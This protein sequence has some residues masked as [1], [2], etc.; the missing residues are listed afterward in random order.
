MNL[1]VRNRY[2]LSKDYIKITDQLKTPRLHPAFGRF[3]IKS[4]WHPL[5]GIS[6][7]TSAILYHPWLREMHANRANK[8][9]IILCVYHF[10]HRKLL[11]IKHIL[12]PCSVFEVVKRHITLNSYM[13]MTQMSLVQNT[14]SHISIYDTVRI[15]TATFLCHFHVIITTRLRGGN[16][17]QRALRALWCKRFVTV[18]QFS[19]F[20]I[21]LCA[22]YSIIC[23]HE[24][25]SIMIVK[26]IIVIVCIN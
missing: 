20:N 12:H 10:L 2:E 14:Q 11:S 23:T 4:V 1:S 19:P 25:D 16:F 18:V 15:L 5:H 13:T 8:P 24:S 17:V 21:I 3:L 22:S 9:C 26:C 7:S 6:L